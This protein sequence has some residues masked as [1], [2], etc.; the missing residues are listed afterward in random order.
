[1]WKICLVMKLGKMSLLSDHPQNIEIL[2]QHWQKDVLKAPAQAR[3]G[4]QA[5]TGTLS[6]LGCSLAQWS[7]TT[8]QVQCRSQP[9]QWHSL[10][11]IPANW[12]SPEPRQGFKG[13]GQHI[14]RLHHR[15]LPLAGTKVWRTSFCVLYLCS[16]AGRLLSVTECLLLVMPQ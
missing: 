12:F 15:A 1:M 6:E 13:S 10:T 2:L 9:P 4:S 8:C 3:E 11:W 14:K 5:W 16:L 7:W